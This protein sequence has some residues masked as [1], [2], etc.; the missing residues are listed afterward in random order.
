[1]EHAAARRALGRRPLISPILGVVG[2]AA[3]LTAVALLVL[4]GLGEELPAAALAAGSLA[5]FGLLEIGVQR[6]RAERN[7]PLRKLFGDLIDALGDAG[8][9]A[10]TWPR[11]LPCLRAVVDE[12]HVAFHLEAAGDRLRIGLTA[13]AEPAAHLWL[14]S[15]QPEDYPHKLEERLARHL[16][17]LSVD[18]AALCALSADAEA[19]EA[20]LAEPGVL[21]ALRSLLADDAP[22]A[23]TL[24]VSP[25]G[26]RWDA[27]LTDRIGAD[28]LLDLARRL[29][30][31]LERPVA[32][33]AEEP[34]PAATPA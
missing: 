23:A 4:R 18:D 2:Q 33:A 12:R 34:G 32:E 9:P 6:R 19:A 22:T 28:R 7:R 26:I 5:L 30:P 3:A 21:E 15:R 14:V 11:G 16:T 29:P 13:A 20:L 1:M 8:R 31:L 27:A 24:E 17:R 10:L 25:E